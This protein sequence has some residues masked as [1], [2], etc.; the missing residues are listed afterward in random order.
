MPEVTDLADQEIESL[1]FDLEYDGPALASHEMDVRE[2]APALL[3]TAD[4]FHTLNRRM[5]PAGRDVQVNIRAST[6][7][8][9]L[10]ELKLVYDTYAETF[11][12]PGLLATEGLASLF[13]VAAGIFVWLRKRGKVGPPVGEPRPVGGDRVEIEWPDGTRLEFNCEVPRL[14]DD[15]AI[16]TS[17]SQLAAPVANAGIE[18]LRI[19]RSGVV[20]GEV[21]Q[22][23]L[24]AFQFDGGNLGR[25]VLSSSER[26]MYLRIL[27]SAWQ[28]GRK[29]RFSDGRWP[30][31]AEI[32]D[33]EFNR[34]L[35][36]GERY[37]SRD[38]L[39]CRVREVQWRD[40]RGLHSEIT[41][42]EVLDRL[43]AGEQ[44]A[45]S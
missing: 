4:L 29:W 3:S 15:A 32:A 33:D 13:Y 22:D 25:E 5:N 40:D 21:E 35:A 8:S 19:R 10:V 9:F 39:D 42:I 24:P 30:F 17:V 27:L 2:L 18:S 41:V 37:G 14:V 28:V 7:G 20:E 26:E 38:I 12:N 44:L 11:T 31:W 1:D 45:F 6:E 36:A 16:R 43:E 23:D 34:Q